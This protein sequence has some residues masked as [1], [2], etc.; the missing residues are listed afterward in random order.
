MDAFK[1]LFSY[2][3]GQAT[4]P[5]QQPESREPVSIPGSGAAAANQSALY[6]DRARQIQQQQYDF[7][8]QV[9]AKGGITADSMVVDEPSAGLHLFESMKSE[10]D[11]T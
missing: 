2:A 1:K 8:E 7:I 5:D 3:P 6:W 10:P 9:N 11:S 4:V